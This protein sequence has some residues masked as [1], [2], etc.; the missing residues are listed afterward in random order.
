MAAKAMNSESKEEEEANL[1]SK[2]Q[3]HHWTAQNL[4]KDLRG[5]EVLEEPLLGVSRDIQLTPPPGGK[6]VSSSSGIDTAEEI[7]Y[8]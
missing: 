8:L 2:I 3:N 6:R 4:W 5:L 1:L 7:L